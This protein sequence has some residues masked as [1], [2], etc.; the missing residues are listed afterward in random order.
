M[1]LGTTKRLTSSES[2]SGRVQSFAFSVSGPDIA[3][4]PVSDLPQFPDAV[5]GADHRTAKAAHTTWLHLGLAVRCE[6]VIRVAGIDEV[7]AAGTQQSFHPLNC[8]PDHTAR[9]A[10]LNLALQLDEGLIRA[11]ETPC[12]DRGNVKQ[13]ERLHPQ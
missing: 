6:W 9:L 2:P 4:P 3:P 13:R 7:D 5:G 1:T 10:R 12:Q 8:F 11:I